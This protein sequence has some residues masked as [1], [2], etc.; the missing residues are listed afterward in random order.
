MAKILCSLSGIEYNCDHFPAYIQKVSHHPVFDMG[1]KSLWKYY[2]K[3][4]TGELTDTDSYLLYLAMLHSTDL[5]EFRIAA[6]RTAHTVSIVQQ[7]MEMLY[8]TIGR[9][10]TIKHPA[11]ILPRFIVSKDTR[12]LTN[13]KVWLQIWNDKYADFQ[14][15]LKDQELRSKLERREASLSKLIR[16]PAIKPERYAHI[17]ATWAAEAAEFP[18]FNISLSDGTST[19]ISE[20]WQSIIVSCYRAENIIQYLESDIVECLTH[21]EDNIELG[22]IFSHQLFNTLREGLDSHRSFF[23][24]GT[25]SFTLLGDNDDVGDANLQ[26]LIQSAPTSEPKRSDYPTEFA[27]LRAKMNWNLSQQKDQGDTK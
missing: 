23:G 26:L 19:T 25:T 10:I 1:L 14:S 6:Q 27:Y 13:T 7:N 4:Q 17:L 21:C 20:Y 8:D 15:G 9:V 18:D 16:N 24:I 11:F 12:D 3:W 22:T 2:P 5:V